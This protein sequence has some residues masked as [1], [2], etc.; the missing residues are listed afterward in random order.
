LKASL[1]KTRSLLQTFRAE[2][3]INPTSA[4]NTISLGTKPVNKTRTTRTRKKG[5]RVQIYLGSNRNDAYATQSR[6]RGQHAD[7]DSYINYDEPNYRVKV[8]DFTSRTEANNFMR[9]LRN[10]Y[11]NVFVVQEDIWVWE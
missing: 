10:Q 4:R 3:E 2:N 7:M 9:T 11:S 5:F 8:G 6:F 1:W